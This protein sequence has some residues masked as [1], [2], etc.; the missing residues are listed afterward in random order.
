MSLLVG[1]LYFQ[2]DLSEEGR[3]GGREGGGCWL[4]MLWTALG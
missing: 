2:L 3:E 1:S 4:L